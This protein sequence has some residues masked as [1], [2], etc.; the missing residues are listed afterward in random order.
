MELT[1]GLGIV[2]AVAGV[3]FTLTLLV[4]VI[5]NRYK[6]A[7]PD[8]A[9]I[10]TGRRGK[11]G[12][13]ADAASQR[14]VTGGGIFVWPIVQQ[15]FSISLSSHQIS[16]TADAQTSNKVTIS[17]RAV[18]IVKV[19]DS[20]E[21]IRAAAQ[22][23]LGKD[24][25]GRITQ[26]TQEVLS[27]TLR[28]LL[29]QLD[30]AQIISD[31][32][33]LAQSVLTSAE[34]ALSKQGLVV[35]TFQIQ[36]ISDSQNYIRNLGLP[37]EARVEQEAKVARAMADKVAREA[38]IEA[39]QAIQQRQRALDLERMA[40][41]VE[42]DR[43][44]AEAEASR[45]LQAAIQAQEV[46]KQ[47]AEVARAR[48]EVRAQ[49]LEA[50]VKRV[51]EAEAYRI[52]Q[53]ATANADALVRK[54]N[55][56]KEQEFARA[57]AEQK[58]GEA[59]AAVEKAQGL[60][61]A[62]VIGTTGEKE[63]EAIK[64]KGLAEAEAKNKLAEAYQKEKEALLAEKLVSI[65]PDIYRAVAEPISNISELTIL[66]SDGKGGASSLASDIGNTVA[67]VQQGLK[68]TTGI[69]IASVLSGV[70]GGTLT[71]GKE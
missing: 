26:Y 62:E 8:Q 63:A 51:A 50:E 13:A 4:L 67:H 70:L 42:V 49:E 55:A 46:V 71:S 3:A 14:V 38:E 53:L 47:E 54:A 16:V 58:R 48:A 32:E 19:N 57:E 5:K 40:I 12:T 6:I 56:E 29:G 69:D 17:A 15:S 22:R 59:I 60:A 35:D 33:R 41:Q 11:G 39:Q 64:A 10:V 1:G 31:R 36:E 2:L 43:A 21:G 9:I 27:G 23:F 28:G 52:E 25:T 44:S 18:A 30:V 68:A 61:R 24:Q 7:S 65:L 45:P 37:E 66:A 34:E 20:A